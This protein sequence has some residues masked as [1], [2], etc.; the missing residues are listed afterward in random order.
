MESFKIIFFWTFVENV[1]S[2][3]MVNDYK[4]N[5]D[6]GELFP[7]SSKYR[8]SNCTMMQKKFFWQISMSLTKDRWTGKHTDLM[9]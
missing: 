6:S 7:E 2:D 8:V 4:S 9:K 1:G 3:Q 5:A